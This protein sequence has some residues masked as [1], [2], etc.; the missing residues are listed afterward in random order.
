MNSE[1]PKDNRVNM[2]DLLCRVLPVTIVRAFKRINQSRT[3]FEETLT[4]FQDQFAAFFASSI[5]HICQ[6]LHQ[7]IGFSSAGTPFHALFIEEKCRER[8]N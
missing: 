5:A 1:R 6:L 8:R 4:L 2:T 7:D 3:N